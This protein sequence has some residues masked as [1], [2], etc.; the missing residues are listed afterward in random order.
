MKIIKLSV[1]LIS[2]ITILGCANT[3]TTVQPI[4][5]FNVTAKKKIAIFF[6]GTQNEENSRT[7]I[8]K[9]HSLVSLQDR[10]DVHT[11]YIQ[12]VGT[13]GE[14]ESLIFGMAFGT[15]IE[16]DVKQAY[17]F[18]GQ[19][20]N[21]SSNDEIFLFGFSRGSHSAR[22]LAGLISVAGIPDLKSLKPAAIDKAIDNIFEA[23]KG[24]KT[25]PERIN[26]INAS[27]SLARKQ[28]TIKFMGLWD[29]VE[30]LGFP[31]PKENWSKFG[32]RIS[33]TYYDQLCNIDYAVHAMSID[34]FRA[35][36]FTP[37]LLTYPELVDDCPHKIINN[38]V[39][40]VWFSGA[41]SD[42]GGGYQDTELDG[43]SLNWMLGELIGY[44]LVP[45]GSQ[46][47]EDWNGISH[48]PRKGLWS[49]LFGKRNRHIPKYS[50]AGQYPNGLLPIHDSVIKRLEKGRGKNWFEFNWT[51]E[52]NYKSCFT[53]ID[54]T[55]APN[56][57]EKQ[58]NLVLKN[59]QDCFNVISTQYPT[60]N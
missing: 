52:N 38:F 18:L 58:C 33:D 26:D 5:S 39:N 37:T 40:E 32:G 13:G 7:N 46:V 59:N 36:I 43:V 11:I 10:E 29:T 20:F 6:D 31:D 28:T 51:D 16:R 1:L 35:K 57:F 45:Q 56:C 23:Y 34:D 9:L 2:A 49:L 3:E 44:D 47:I 12:G 30:A 22:V 17:K 27:T 14:G 41:H 24:D 48:D 50:E 53:S 25:K 4:K 8:S 60:L 42:V 15:G 54:G 19:R 21:L 55:E